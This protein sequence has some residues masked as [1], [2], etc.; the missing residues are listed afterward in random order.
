MLLESRHLQLK[1]LPF[2]VQRAM[3]SGVAY[4]YLFSYLRLEQKRTGL[5]NNIYIIKNVMIFYLY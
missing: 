1:I 4:I 2:S 3:T 5:Y